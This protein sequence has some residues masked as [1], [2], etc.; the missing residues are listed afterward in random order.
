MTT[1]AYHE[2]TTN[3]TG[4]HAFAWGALLALSLLFASMLQAMATKALV[5]PDNPGGSSTPE[6]CAVSLGDPMYAEVDMDS[7]IVAHSRQLGCGRAALTSI[8]SEVHH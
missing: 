8:Q 5:A 2:V 1:R 7:S 3:R 4:R 6:H